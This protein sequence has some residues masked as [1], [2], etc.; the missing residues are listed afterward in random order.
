MDKKLRTVVLS[1]IALLTVGAGALLYGASGVAISAQPPLEST[2][3]A[4]PPQRFEVAQAQ[5]ASSEGSPLPGGASSLSE[6]YQDWSVS[7][8]QQE[9]QKRCTFSQVQVQ[10]S[11]QR[12]LAIELDAPAGNTVTGLLVLPFGLALDA[13]IVFQVDE[14]APMQPVRFRTCLPAGCLV[15]VVLDAPAIVALRGGAVLKVQAV[16]DGGSPAEF[17]VSL[18]GFGTALDRVAVLAS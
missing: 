10:Q 14:L 18:Q 8:L 11:G 6:T 9:A 17:S 4:S 3:T 12:V 5:D 13:G 1:A 15:P 16:A 2:L 7:C